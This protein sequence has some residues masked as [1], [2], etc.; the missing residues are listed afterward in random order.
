[1]DTDRVAVSYLR[2]ARQESD[3]FIAP[4]CLISRNRERSLAHLAIHF[5]SGGCHGSSFLLFGITK[6]GYARAQRRWTKKRRRR[7]RRRRWWRRRRKKKKKRRYGGKKKTTGGRGGRSVIVHLRITVPPT[8][9][10]IPDHLV[11]PEEGQVT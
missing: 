6:S 8:E 4:L 1:M 3:S 2:N 7:R 9:G 10:A 5:Q 11:S